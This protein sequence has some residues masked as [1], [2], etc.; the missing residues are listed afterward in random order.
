MSAECATGPAALLLRDIPPDEMLPLSGK[1][2]LTNFA[3]VQR[4]LRMTM[5]MLA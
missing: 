4:R 5:M 2:F 1:Q 3:S